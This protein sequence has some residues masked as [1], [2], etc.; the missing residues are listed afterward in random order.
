MWSKVWKMTPVPIPRF[1]ILRINVAERPCKRMQR[2][3][4]RRILAADVLSHANNIVE[5]SIRSQTPDLGS[6]S[7]RILSLFNILVLPN[8][9]IAIDHRMVRPERGIR[10]GVVEI[11]RIAADQV[12]AR[13][14]RAHAAKREF[15]LED[16]LK[17]SNIGVIVD[18]TGK[19][20][21]AGFVGGLEVEIAHHASGIIAQAVGLGIRVGFGPVG[22]SLH[23]LDG[24]HVHFPTEGC[25]N[26]AFGHVHEGV[27]HLLFEWTGFHTPASSS[28]LELHQAGIIEGKA[29]IIPPWDIFAIPR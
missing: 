27:A 19:E 13:G 2:I 22:V 17:G 24:A 16:G 15:A 4:N 26:D 11:G 29:G 12:V 18:E 28:R 3:P 6:S 14:M 25:V 20:W 10:R 23:G 7:N 21:V 9:V 1:A 8:P 5:R